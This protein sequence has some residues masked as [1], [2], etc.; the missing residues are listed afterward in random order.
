MM[1]NIKGIVR[2]LL[3]DHIRRKLYHL[4]NARLYDQPI[5]S[6]YEVI[7]AETAAQLRQGWTSPAIPQRQY[8]A[9]KPLLTQMYQGYSRED[10]VALAR[11][12]QL[13]TV[14]HPVII[15]VGCGNGWNAEVLAHLLNYPVHYLG[16][17]YSAAMVALAKQSYSN[18]PFLTADAVALP[19]QDNACDILV[20]GTA[21]MHILDYPLAIQESRRVAGRWCVFHTVPVLKNRETTILRKQ[22]YGQWS[23]E[24]IFNEEAL[25]HLFS[26]NGLIISDILDSLPYNLEAVLGEP[27]ITRTYL[28]RVE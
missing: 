26:E 20:S 8:L 11:A 12:V 19:L 18:I 3:P 10:F 9:F 5:S 17:D 28:C 14:P 15:E 27:T 23:V 22:A 1:D 7:T 21:L 4:L 6:G 2:K 25:C 13:T 24:I 16:L